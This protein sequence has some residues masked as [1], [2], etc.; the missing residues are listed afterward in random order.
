[1]YAGCAHCFD[2][3]RPATVH[4][5]MLLSHPEHADHQGP[6]A[7]PVYGSHQIQD[8]GQCADS[9]LFAL[10]VGI[11]SVMFLKCDVWRLMLVV[12]ID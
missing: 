3:P 12:N 4:C 5:S 7:Q 6:N 8:T 11:Y 1:M 10:Y 2:Y 9:L